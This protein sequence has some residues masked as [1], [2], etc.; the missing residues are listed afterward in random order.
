MSSSPIPLKAQIGVAPTRLATLTR[1]SGTGSSLAT[2]I[3]RVFPRFRSALG[4][5]DFD[6]R[7]KMQAAILSDG[8]LL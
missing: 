4:P 8:C 1:L 2:R 3:L 5:F 6:L 7:P